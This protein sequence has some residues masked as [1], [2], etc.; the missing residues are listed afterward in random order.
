MQ[1]LTGH[2]R[3][4]LRRTVGQPGS[5]P[6]DRSAGTDGSHRVVCRVF[7][8]GSTTLAC[9]IY[10]RSP[11]AG[12]HAVAGEAIGRQQFRASDTDRR[13]VQGAPVGVD[14]NQVRARSAEARLIQAGAVPPRIMQPAKENAARKRCVNALIQTLR[15]WHKRH[16]PVALTLACNRRRPKLQVSPNVFGRHRTQLP[17]GLF[18]HSLPPTSGRYAGIGAEGVNI[19]VRGSGGPC[20]ID[21]PEGREGYEVEALFGSIDDWCIIQS[22]MTFSCLDSK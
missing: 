11:D 20:A 2:S 6:R 12:L 21:P 18:L 5:H 15:V 7:R 9:E 3:R 16:L 19:D 13:V 22:N 14:D 1:T 10:E 8:A 4:R 17:I